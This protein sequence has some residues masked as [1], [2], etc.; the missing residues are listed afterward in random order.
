MKEAAAKANADKDSD[1]NSGNSGNGGQNGNDKRTINAAQQSKLDFYVPY[2]EYS[3]MTP[4]QRSDL[5][6]QR[7]KARE[8]QPRQVNV[9]QVTQTAQP[10]VEMIT[11]PKSLLTIAMSQATIP[12][13]AT[14]PATPGTVNTAPASAA[15]EAEN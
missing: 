12:V 11:L 15:N 9:A 5:Y 13:N 14:T 2:E 3:K 8:Q 1:N 4:K 6:E 10:E 7:K